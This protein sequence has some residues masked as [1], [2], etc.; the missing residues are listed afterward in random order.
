MTAFSDN[1]LFLRERFSNFFFF[2]T[3]SS[4]FVVSQL[5]ISMAKINKQVNKI[6]KKLALNFIL[7]L[8]PSKL[9]KFMNIF[10]ILL[11]CYL[12]QDLARKLR[13]YM[14][15]F[16]WKKFTCLHVSRKFWKLFLL[17]RTLSSFITFFKKK[18]SFNFI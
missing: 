3:F 7:F 16:R 2:E 5:K 12:L 17:K 15:F 10:Q 8:F 18:K 4:S 11:F 1:T 9:S 6:N 13:V 14:E